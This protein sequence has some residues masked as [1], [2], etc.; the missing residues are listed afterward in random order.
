MT[1]RRL[2][3][4]LGLALAVAAVA[5]SAT[6]AGKPTTRTPGVLTVAIELGNPGFSEGTIAHPTGFS[7]DMGRAVA[8][9]LG[10]RVRYV[11][12]PFGRLFLPGAKPYDVAFEFATILASRER[13]V[14]FSVPYYASRQAVLV[15]SDTA[16]PTSLAALRKIQVCA[17]ETTTG[18]AFIQNVLRPSTLVL[19]YQTAPAALHAL[20]KSICDGFVFDLPALMAAKKEHPS[21]YGALAGKF[22]PTE[23]YGAVLS[24]GSALKPAVDAAIHAL[25]RAGVPTRFAQKHFGSQAAVP[26]L[27]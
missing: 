9:R 19:E 17:K 16:T 20:S 13:L 2:L 3:P 4:V 25:V 8:S 21:L 12:Y 5:V 6:S 1:M 27:H 18:L 22:G 24:K 26:V 15:S 10:L 11:E 7:V 14:D 23:Q